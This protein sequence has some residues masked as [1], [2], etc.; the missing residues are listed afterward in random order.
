MMLSTISILILSGL[1]AAQN[2]TEN[3]SASDS[4]IPTPTSSTSI[5]R[6]AVANPTAFSTSIE[7]NLDEYW[8][9]LIGPVSTA[10]INTTV[11]ATPVPTNELTPPPGLHYSSFPTGQ[12]IPLVNKNESWSFPKDF[13]WGVASAA[14]Q[15]EGAVKAEGRGPSIWDALLHRV[16][17]YSVANQTGDIADNQY[18]LYKQ[19]MKE[20]TTC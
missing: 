2:G 14:Y 8:D 5:S 18:Y 17:G 12:Q 1:T 7:L 6:V 11:A 4:I 20:R 13:W 3:S 16:T 19:G 15:V 10:T 9:L